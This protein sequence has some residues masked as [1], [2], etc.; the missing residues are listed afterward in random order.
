MDDVG[1]KIT[2]NLKNCTKIVKGETRAH[3]KR[4]RNAVS[5]EARAVISESP[6]NK[7]SQKRDSTVLAGDLKILSFRS[8]KE[9]GLFT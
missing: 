5:R 9:C 7:P 4:A 8:C 1:G 3:Q 2:M 6:Y